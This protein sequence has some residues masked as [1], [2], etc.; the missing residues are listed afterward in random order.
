MVEKN[1]GY[2]NAFSQL[3]LRKEELTVHCS[4]CDN[5]W[6]EEVEHYGIFAG[7]ARNYDYCSKCMTPEEKLESSK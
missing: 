4:R 6:L 2:N 1:K 3:K 7:Y 5:T